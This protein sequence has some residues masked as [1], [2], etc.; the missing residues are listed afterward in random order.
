MIF[1]A[2]IHSKEEKKIIDFLLKTSCVHYFLSASRVSSNRRCAWEMSLN[3]TNSSYLPA[4]S[5]EEGGAG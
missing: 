2:Q 4:A 3:K 5:G 1:K